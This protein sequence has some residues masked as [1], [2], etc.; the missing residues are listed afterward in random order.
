MCGFDPRVDEPYPSEIRKQYIPFDYQGTESEPRAIEN[1]LEEEQ[2]PM[3]YEQY[4]ECK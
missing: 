4:P 3:V 1:Q 2:E